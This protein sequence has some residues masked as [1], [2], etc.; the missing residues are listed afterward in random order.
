MK[1]LVLVM[2]LNIN[3]SYADEFEA[4][5]RQLVIDLKSSLMKNLSEQM[6]KK[7]PLEAISFCHDNV[8][9]IARSA[10]KER[11]NKFEFGRTSHKI[12]NEK[13]APQSWAVP[14]IKEFQGKFQGD[15]KKDFIIHRLENSKRVYL[16]PLYVQAQCLTC[17]GENVSPEL[18][19]KIKSLYPNDKAT[20]FKIGEFRGFIWVKEK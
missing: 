18:D 11:I 3:T 14:Y 16:S 9:P 8:I 13:N 7:G 12:R 4:E 1:Y 2:L 15:M 20:G 6:S 5:A 19:K 10:A 17:H